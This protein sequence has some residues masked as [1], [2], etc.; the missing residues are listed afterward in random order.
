MKNVEKKEQITKGRESNRKR[1]SF[2]GVLEKYI[3]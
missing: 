2:K 1:C 3:L